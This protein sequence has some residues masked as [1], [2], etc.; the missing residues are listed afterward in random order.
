MVHLGLQLLDEL[1]L[2]CIL[3]LHG[4]P[5]HLKLLDPARQ[6]E[7]LLLEKMTLTQVLVP[8]L[9]HLLKESLVLLVDRFK[10]TLCQLYLLIRAPQDIGEMVHLLLQ[11]R[12]DPFQLYPLLI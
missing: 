8:Q 10:L 4:L 2:L 6:G 1:L 5:L 11:V 7:L 12:N 3:K 9:L